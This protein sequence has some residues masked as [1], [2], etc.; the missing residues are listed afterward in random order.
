MRPYLPQLPPLSLYIH[1]PWCVRKCPYCDFNSHA[2]TASLPEE[3]YTEALI[4]DL[5]TALSRMMPRSIHSI[6]FGGGTP[7]L[8]SPDAIER[9]L[10]QVRKLCHVPHEIEI[11]LEA[12]P[13]TA[14]SHHFSGYRQ[15]GVNRLSLGIQS[16]Q[17]HYLQALGRVHSA[18]EAIQAIELA[19]RY[20]D[21]LNLDLM[22]GL[23][24]QTLDH[25]KQ[26]VMTALTFSPSHLSCYQLTLEP[27]TPFYQHPPPLPAEDIIERMDTLIV[28]TLVQAN[29]QRY[30]VSAFAKDQRVSQHNLNYWRFGD[31]LGIGAGA[32]SKLSYTHHIQRERRHQHP[33][34]YLKYSAQNQAIAETHTVPHHEIGFEFMLNAL[35]LHEPFS[36]DDFYMRTGLPLSIVQQPLDQAKTLGFITEINSHY[37][38]TVRGK[39]LLNEALQL[40]LNMRNLFRLQV[41]SQPAQSPYAPVLALYH[42]CDYGFAQI[43]LK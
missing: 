5:E 34:A 7:S 39:R 20:F 23:P 16:F 13:A 6:F 2:Q 38:T 22:Y 12:N 43:V 19:Q 41:V 32:H 36:A 28:E 29:Y 24:Q 30:E 14:D 31:Y 1:I 25:A 17:D 35:R 21:N 37:T 27:H 18:Q 33:N 26:D 4:I 10:N 42:P 11:T 9:I 40:F 15:A 8:F 3:A